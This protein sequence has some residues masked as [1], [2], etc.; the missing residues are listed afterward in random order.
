MIP[1]GPE[2]I[3]TEVT[4]RKIVRIAAGGIA[5]Y[6]ALC[7]HHVLLRIIASRLANVWLSSNR[8]SIYYRGLDVEI[9]VLN[10]Y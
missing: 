3:L 6:I 5:L 7:C 9:T 8:E 2:M 4:S 10:E 1:F